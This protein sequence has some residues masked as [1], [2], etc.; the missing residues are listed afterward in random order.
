MTCE[1]FLRDGEL[2]GKPRRTGADAQNTVVTH[3]EM[4]LS[5]ERYISERCEEPRDRFQFENEIVVLGKLDEEFFAE[6][7]EVPFVL[8]MFWNPREDQFVETDHLDAAFAEV[9]EAFVGERDDDARVGFRDAEDLGEEFFRFGDVFDDFAAEDDVEA[10]VGERHL[11]CGLDTEVFDV[12][13]VFEFVFGPSDGCFA[14]VYAVELAFVNEV[15]YVATAATDFEDCIVFLD[16]TVFQK[17]LQSLRFNVA[18]QGVGMGEAAFVGV[19]LEHR[20]VP[21]G[22]FLVGGESALGHRV[23]FDVGGI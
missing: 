4:F 13:F 18:E 2:K 8:H 23:G 14:E 17:V 12:G 21:G 3:L 22:E 9:D 20:L 15:E 10:V 1:F 7:G 6:F 19:L 11:F 5:Y 16:V